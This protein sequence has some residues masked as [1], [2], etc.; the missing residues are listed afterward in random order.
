M[1]KRVKSSGLG[2]GRKGVEGLHRS[3]ETGFQTG[4][5]SVK[6]KGNVN[7]YIVHFHMNMLTAER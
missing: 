4:R 7:L 2:A 3:N 5:D 1:G 6:W